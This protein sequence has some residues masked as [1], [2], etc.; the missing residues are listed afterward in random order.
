MR[1][2][3]AG[4]DFM[5]YFCTTA[6]GTHVLG[7]KTPLMCA[8]LS[9]SGKKAAHAYIMAGELF[10]DDFFFSLFWLCDSF[11]C[12]W[13]M[14][15]NHSPWLLS[16]IHSLT[17]LSIVLSWFTLSFCLSVILILP[18]FVSL[19]YTVISFKVVPDDEKKHW[20]ISVPLYSLQVA[21]DSGCYSALSIFFHVFRCPPS[22]PH[23]C[24]QPPLIFEGTL[25][26]LCD[27]IVHESH[28]TGGELEIM[29]RNGA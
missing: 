23:L 4:E 17:I 3:S 18:V 27:V 21:I 2:N 16:N 13:K 19:F 22:L 26:S 6:H 20:N 29:D 7:N 11:A 14:D 1:Q 24:R 8:L 5:I 28:V 10:W 25:S 9:H 12:R 15:V